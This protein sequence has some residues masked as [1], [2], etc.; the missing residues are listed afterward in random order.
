VQEEHI[1]KTLGSCRFVYNYYLEKKISLY[2]SEKKSL[3]H[4]KCSSDLTLLKQQEEYNWLNDV[5]RNAL[6]N[7]LEDLDTAFSNFFR[8]IKKGNCNY[9]LP[10]FKRK[11]KYPQ[12]YRLDWALRRSGV[13]PS[14]EIKNN[15]IK[16]HKLGWVKISNSRNVGGNIVSATISKTASGK[17]YI[18]VCCNVDDSSVPEISG[19]VALDLGIKDYFTDS[20][21]NKILNPCLIQSFDEHIRQLDRILSRKQKGSHNYEKLRIKRAKLHEHIRNK[22]I[23]FLHKLSSKLI[24]DNQVIIMEDLNVKGMIEDGYVAKYIQDVG[25][26]EFRI[27][28]EYKAL[29]NNRR[30][31]LI[32]RFFPSSQICSQCGYKNVETRN[33]NVRKWIC[34]N[35][36]TEHD[37]DI[38]AAKNILNEGLK[39]I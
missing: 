20:N 29:K 30:V 33:L 1:N 15:K 16:L 8:E 24:N 35:C 19:I 5:A 21:G 34:P 39:M 3:S 27:M 14:I 36:N 26:R 38:N 6:N 7:S 23:D 31:I 17:Y 32:D 9:G 22:R 11:H 13:A 25:W 18:S 12:S 4:N 28:I 10:K 37:R 2:K